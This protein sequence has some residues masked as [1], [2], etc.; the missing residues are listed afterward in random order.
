MSPFKYVVWAA[1]ICMLPNAS[2]AQ[3]GSP[4]TGGPGASGPHVLPEP[5]EPPLPTMLDAKSDAV[6]AQEGLPTAGLTLAELEQMALAR[7]PTLAQAAAQIA[8]A[9]GRYVQ[10]GLYP[11]PVAGYMGSEIG[12][13][14]RAGQQGGFVSQEVVTAGKRQ[15]SR[16]VVSQ[17]IRQGEYVWEAQRQ[18]IVTDVRSG[19]YDVL[20]AQLAVELTEQLVRIGD[21]S[22][23]SADSLMKEKEVGRGDVLQARIESDTAKVLLER[24]R[25][26][27]LGAWRQLAAVVGDAAMEPQ[28]LIGEVQEGLTPLDW[29]DTFQRLLSQ[30]PELAQAEAG[31][32]RAQAA[33]RRECAGRYPNVDLQAA[34]QYDNSTYDTFGSVQVGVP[35]PLFDRN[36]GNIRRAQ[37]ELS[38]A[39]NESQRVQLALQQR[40]GRAFEQYT[41]ALYQVQKYRQDILPNA[42]ASLKLTD[43]G[44][45]L[46]EFSYLSLLTAQRTYFQTNLAYLDALRDLRASA[47]AIEGNLLTDSLQSGVSTDRG[48]S[49]D[50]GGGSSFGTMSNLFQPR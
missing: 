32:A 22:V 35:V 15:L 39:Q 46:G 48:P 45:R 19:F 21:A 11:N 18:R 16:N 4:A 10:A 12:N 42:E 43:D 30:S 50:S 37:A 40:L 36:Q 17:E 49:Q 47:T 20:I 8:A 31:V 38:A 44:Y 41:N 3:T 28:R 27:H 23:K 1:M 5:S 25:N 14:G 9:Q 13:A 33:L 6:V 29:N 7:N 2:M 26:R 24:A 34:V